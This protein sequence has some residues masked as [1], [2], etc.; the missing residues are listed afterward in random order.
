[1]DKLAA[2]RTPVIVCYNKSDL[3][4]NPQ[5]VLNEAMRWPGAEVVA[6]AA[7]DRNS[8]MRGL[9]PAMLRAVRGRE[10]WLARR[11]PM[12]REPVCR[13]LIDDTSFIN[14][15]YSLTTGLA[16]INPVLDMPLNVADM[17]G[18]DQEPGVDGV[19]DRAGDGPA[20]RLA[21]D[22][23]QAGDGGGRRVS[24]AAGGA[25]TH[26]ADSGVWHHSQDRRVL[27][28]DVCRRPGDLSWCVNGEKLKPEALKP[29]YAEALER[30]RAAGQSLR[31][32]AGRAKL[33]L[34]KPRLR[35]FAPPPGVCRL[36]Q[37][38]AQGRDVL[39]FLRPECYNRLFRLGHE[40][41]ALVGILF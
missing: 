30:G 22:D 29:L 4:Q 12:L 20:F 18:V 28:G 16:E 33:A 15:A 8:L 37:E 27:C 6:I 17:V 2:H 14:G 11:L 10:I 39:R 31:Q 35:L 41:A 13:K 5:A 34:P 40:Q 1:M 25:P 21:R 26:R 3:A 36:R 19:Q 9:V 24:M 7:P 32:N 38:S 23:P